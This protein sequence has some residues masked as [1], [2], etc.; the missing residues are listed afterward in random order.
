MHISA[1]GHH[2]GR[3][4]SVLR[5]AP[6]CAS[7]TTTTAAVED[8]CACNIFNGSDTQPAGWPCHAKKLTKTAFWWVQSHSRSSMLTNLRSP[9]SVLVTICSNSEPICNRFHTIRANSGKITFFKGVPFF[10]AFIRR[11]PPHPGARNFVTKN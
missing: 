3:A 1:G 10:D 5:S 11:E 4:N 2:A 7:S 6:A 8:G 9:S